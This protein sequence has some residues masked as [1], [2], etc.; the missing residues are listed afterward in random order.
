MDKL[1]AHVVD[2]SNPRSLSSRARR[3]RWQKFIEVFPDIGDMQVLDLGGMADYWLAAPVTPAHV[4]LVNLASTPSSD[5]ITAVH[6]DACNLPED[7]AAKTF[8]IVVSNSLI[9]HVGGHAQRAK[10]ADTVR[11]SAPRHWVQTPYRYFPIEPHWLAPAFQFVPF[12][13]RVRWTL[14]WRLG[15]MHADNRQEA[16]DLVNDVELIGLTQMRDYFPNSTIWAERAGG[17]V[18]SMVAI[19][20]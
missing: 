13:V 9:E 20:G 8:D 11:R 14:R 7:V 5:R 12:E 6:G 2:H 1:S 17:L 15:H 4:T 19:R 18:K 10:L 3:K 16:V